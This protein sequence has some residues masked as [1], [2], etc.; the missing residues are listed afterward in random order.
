[1]ITTNGLATGFGRTGLIILVSLAFVTRSPAP[2][3]CDGSPV[4]SIVFASAP[5]IAEAGSGT[6]Q[7][8]FYL[9]G[10]VGNDTHLTLQISGTAVNGVD[11]QTLPTQVTIPAGQTANALTLTA[12]PDG[13]TESPETVTVTITA[14]DNA[15]VNVGSPSAAT[16]TI[17]EAIPSLG[18][19]LDD[20]NLVWITGSSAWSAIST[21]THDGVDAAQSGITG[22]QQES[23]LQTTVNGPGTLT[24]WWKVS[25]E[26]DFDWLR[27]HI[28]GVLQ[29]QISG[30]IGWQQLSFQL[31]TGGHTLRWRYVKDVNGLGG[32]DKAWVDQVSFTVASGAPVIVVQPTDQIAWEGA[33]V[34]VD[35]VAFGSLPLSQQWFINTSTPIP[36]AT[37]ASLVLNSLSSMQAGL[38]SLIVSNAQGSATSSV[39]RV[40]LTNNSPVIQVLLFSDTLTYSP[41]ESALANLG[42]T[43]QKFYDEFSFNAAVNAANPPDTLAIVDAPQSGFYSFSSFGGFLN[44]GGRV[45]IQAYT[46]A[47]HPTLATTLQVAIENRSSAALPLNNWSGSPLFSSLTS[48]V[49]FGP[50]YLYEEAQRLHPLLGARSVAGYLS[51]V[52]SGEAAI[53]IGNGGRSIVNG[54]YAEGASLSTDAIRLAQNEISFLIG[55]FGPPAPFMSGFFRSVSGR[56]G[57]STGGM[58]GQVVIVDG[59]TDLST[60][61]PLKTNTLSDVPVTFTDR[62]GPLLPYRFY[63]LRSS[64]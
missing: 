61:T 7:F 56:F 14:S 49:S 9:S 41:F 12:I 25:S 11:F 3:I 55:A 52:T 20:P 33:N 4:A 10:P 26:V 8:T 63:R 21:T 2:V 42:L 46:L 29:Q 31:P 17:V 1:M 35:T 34:T 47:G 53:V 27:F 5:V 50:I 59:S 44:G 6:A 39:A 19:A 54:F 36:N 48:P 16:I 32:Q 18:A 37:N 43:F 28:D 40:A 60:W 24:F 62:Q 45:L 58:V 38:Y 13:I 51:T 30:E 23:W 64:R 15:C 57:F 22:D